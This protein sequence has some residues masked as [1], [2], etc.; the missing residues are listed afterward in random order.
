MRGAL[1]QLLWPT[2]AEDLDSAPVGT[3]QHRVCDCPQLSAERIQ[4]GP[5]LLTEL[6]LKGEAVPQL[7]RAALTSG[8]Y[9]LPRLRLQPHLVPPPEGTF[10][11]V[12]RKSDQQTLTGCIYTDASRI[13]D[14]H[15]DTVRLGWA[16]VAVDADHSVTAIASGTPPD[17][18]TDIPAAEAWALFQ[19]TTFAELGSVIY[20]D[21]KPCVDGIHS[22]RKAA[23]APSRP[24][25]RV[26]NLIFDNK[27]LLPDTAFV[28]MPSHT[29][30]AAVGRTYLGNGQA[31]TAHDRDA[32]AIADAE[33]K[34]A[35]AAF[36]VNPEVLEDLEAY[37]VAVRQAYG[38]LGH[39]TYMAN[40][41]PPPV[42]RDSEASRAAANLGR[43]VRG[44][45]PRLRPPRRGV[46]VANGTRAASSARSQRWARRAAT[47]TSAAAGA[48]RSNEDKG[49]GVLLRAHQL[50]R[51]GTVT[52]CRVCGAYA[53]RHGVGLA[54]RCP[55]P[56]AD[57]G[58]SGGRAQQLRALLRCRHPKLG[59]RLPAPLPER[60]WA[61]QAQLER[62]AAARGGGRLVGDE[63]AL[64][65]SLL[66]RRQ[67]K[68][69]ARLAKSSGGPPAPAH[70]AAEADASYPTRDSVAQAQAN[71]LIA[72]IHEG[73]SGKRPR[74]GPSATT[75]PRGPDGAPVQRRP[76]A[77]LGTPWRDAF[78]AHR[79][80][81]RGA[82]G[83]G[84]D[85]GKSA[86]T[87]AA[88]RLAA[89]FGRRRGA[90]ALAAAPRVARPATRARAPLESRGRP[91]DDTTG[92]T[93][94][95]PRLHA[96]AGGAGTESAA[97]TEQQPAG[98]P[99]L[100]AAS[101]SVARERRPPSL[102]DRDAGGESAP[103]A[104]R[105]PAALLPDPLVAAR[106][107][108]WGRP[109]GS[110]WPPASRGGA[111]PGV[112]TAARRGVAVSVGEAPPADATA[113]AAEAS[114]CDAVPAATG[115][116]VAT[117]ARVSRRGA[118]TWT[119]AKWRR[120]PPGAAAA[121]RRRAAGSLPP[122]AGATGGPSGAAGAGLAP[123]SGPVGAPASVGAAP[124]YDG[125]QVTSRRRRLPSVL[126]A[127]PG[128][129]RRR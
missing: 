128:K 35:A 86:T 46:T 33:A 12:F 104:G 107:V 119:A 36:A 79:A 95:R 92:P 80:G 83:G 14:G 118:V 11:W 75:E 13:N 19:A 68:L 93:A 97:P 103:H 25:A 28:W 62:Q 39:V 40:H 8:L 52:W 15:P 49:A 64:Q 109:G 45:T 102:L 67:L 74:T 70:D 16:V 48:L 77:A 27:G 54:K 57:D 56:V 87:A 101:R 29:S 89:A 117:L 78:R 91:C 111:P 66:G 24:L 37:A 2:T 58:W 50:M 30:A 61:Q 43:A 60:L 6:L 34:L 98:S 59:H 96:T 17:Y 125:G 123:M 121:A 1:G 51:S 108:A 112:A 114:R 20:S 41:R 85:C 22:G 71:V 7:M 100:L 53:E 47:S 9:P 99:G 124:D 127:R 5:D 10:R 116:P 63:A 105:Q 72:A 65:A 3:L 18:I 113:A 69:R 82:A 84:G 122:L 23:C 32:N 126:P 26:M 88:A 76:S 31:L 106:S 44:T 115:A 55:G 110:R 120:P 81:S 42:R 94:K 73:S 38:W 90:A 129:R 4:L 21:C